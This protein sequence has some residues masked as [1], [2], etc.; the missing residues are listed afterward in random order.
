MNNQ[1]P[2][3]QMLTLTNPR[4]EQFLERSLRGLEDD[5]KSYVLTE[6]NQRGWSFNG[7]VEGTGATINNQAEAMAIIL[8]D[9]ITNEGRK[10]LNILKEDYKKKMVELSEMKLEA[11]EANNK[12]KYDTFLKK[13]EFDIGTLIL[14]VTKTHEFE[15]K[16]EMK[17]ML[18]DLKEMKPFLKAGEGKSYL[19]ALKTAASLQN[20]EQEMRPILETTSKN[21]NNIKEAMDDM[22]KRLISGEYGDGS[23]EEKEEMLKNKAQ[24]EEMH[25]DADADG[26][27]PKKK[28]IESS[29][30]N[31]DSSDE[32]S[33]EEEKK[34]RKTPKKREVSK[35]D[36]GRR[37]ST[38]DYERS[39]MDQ[40]P[41]TSSG[42][43]SMKDDPKKVKKMKRHAEKPLKVTEVVRRLRLGGREGHRNANII[44][45]KILLM[46]QD[47]EAQKTIYVQDRNQAGKYVNP[48]KDLPTLDISKVPKY[49][50]SNTMKDYLKCGTYRTMK[51]NEIYDEIYDENVYGVATPPSI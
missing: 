47:M 5:I 22:R 14:Q 23:P 6:L 39:D 10:L 20:L 26:E 15:E 44:E 38:T 11:M 19:G 27:R 48:K 8:S 37:R 21:V 45:S 13:I 42:K 36:R 30:D 35:E 43:R 28:K 40:K 31:S 25:V 2:N 18:E 50:Y 12:E 7:N 17:T 29:S 1:A 34:K 24:D 32:E 46:V 41:S 4:D 33:S 49:Y 51:E 9:K 16:H 3:G